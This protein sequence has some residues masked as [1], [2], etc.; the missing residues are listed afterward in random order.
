[1]STTIHVI[2]PARLCEEC[3]EEFE[4]AYSP[5]LD[6]CNHCVE[7]LAGI[8]GAALTGG[9]PRTGKSGRLAAEADLINRAPIER[10]ETE[11]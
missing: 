11:V 1:M 4:L 5:E 3:G 6:R 9:C 2:E 7:F 10:A 8:E